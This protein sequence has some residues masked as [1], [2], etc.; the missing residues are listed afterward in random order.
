MSQTK[1]KKKNMYLART[2]RHL[3]VNKKDRLT[4][5]LIMVVPS[6]IAMI[7]FYG[8]MT[9]MMSNI[10]AMALKYMIPSIEISYEWHTFIPWLSSMKTVALPTS[11]PTDS[12][13]IA[14]ILAVLIILALSLLSKYKL[15]PLVIYSAIALFIHLINC[16]FFLFA[17]D[18]FPYSASDYSELYMK[19]QVGIWICFLVITGIVGGILS[20]GGFWMRTAFLAGVMGYSFVFGFIRY[21]LFLYIIHEFSVLYMA[22]FFFVLG[23]FFDFLYLVSIYGIYMN[24][25]TIMYSEG[26]RKGEWVWS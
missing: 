20:A 10:T 5:L 21:M 7:L 19:Q 23:P 11:Y 6:L 15:R 26:D 3:A 16:I 8:N 1:M 12:F 25:L 24:K 14:N 2:Y 17:G 13:V 22:V 9:E 18:H 4:F